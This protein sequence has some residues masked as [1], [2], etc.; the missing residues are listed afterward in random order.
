MA[1]GAGAEVEVVGADRLAFT[2]S[3]V[4]DQLGDL[5]SINGTV[6]RYT[7]TRASAMAPRQ[8]GRLAAS[9]RGTSTATE[10]R[11]SAGAPYAAV[12]EFGWPGHN[13]EG[14]RFM[15]RAAKQSEPLAIR[16]HAANLRRLVGTIKGA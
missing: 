16:L 1:K 2:T 14:H 3:R 10:S 7:A 9:I 12:Q 13:I 5:S 6:A 11:V 8:T 15:G 4:A